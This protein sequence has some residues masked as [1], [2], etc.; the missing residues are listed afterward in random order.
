MKKG[1]GGAAGGGE[2]KE[3]EVKEE[4]DEEEHLYQVYDSLHHSSQYRIGSTRRLQIKLI[5]MK[6]VLRRLN[7]F[8]P[9]NARRK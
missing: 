1:E 2:N 7:E 3:D 9:R 5:E 6:N 4:D 8:Q